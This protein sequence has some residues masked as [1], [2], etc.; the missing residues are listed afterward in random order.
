MAISYKE[1]IGNSLK[2]T[3]TNSSFMSNNDSE[4]KKKKKDPEVSEPN[5]V[6]GSEAGAYND[7]DLSGIA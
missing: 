7:L 3:E 5:E 4:K 6:R 2:E 1:P